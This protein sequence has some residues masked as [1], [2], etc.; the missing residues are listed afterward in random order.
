MTLR[1]ELTKKFV[2]DCLKA[3][4]KYWNNND[5]EM[6]WSEDEHIYIGVDAKNREWITALQHTTVP[7]FSI[8]CSNKQR[9]GNI[10]IDCAAIN[11]VSICD[12]GN[13]TCRTCEKD[14]LISFDIDKKSKAYEI[15][16]NLDGVM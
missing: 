9:K 10:E 7:I 11:F 5:L 16:Q 14:F 13:I 3:P 4:K 8:K 12:E 2:K 15:Y 1:E 6:K